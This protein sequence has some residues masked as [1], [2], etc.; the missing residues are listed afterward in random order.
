MQET[1]AKEK[2]AT[3]SFHQWSA[4]FQVDENLKTCELDI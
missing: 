4:Y 1:V 3:F 2:L